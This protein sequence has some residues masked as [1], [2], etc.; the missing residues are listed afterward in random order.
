MPLIEKLLSQCH[1]WRSIFVT[2]SRHV[3][4]MLRPKL[5]TAYDHQY[6]NVRIRLR[7]SGS[8][9]PLQTGFDS[10]APLAAQPNPRIGLLLLTVALFL[11][12]YVNFS[13]IHIVT[14]TRDNIGRMMQVIL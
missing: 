9:K 6:L 5:K 12:V 2:L 8:F 14:A 3:T 7:A 13:R 11:A 4:W 10:Y 1:R